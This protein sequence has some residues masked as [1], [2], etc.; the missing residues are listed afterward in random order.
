VSCVVLRPALGMCWVLPGRPDE[1]CW[2]SSS[3]LFNRQVA[4]GGVHGQA[5]QQPEAAVPKPVQ[6]S[7]PFLMLRQAML[8]LSAVLRAQAATTEEQLAGWLTP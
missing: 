6:T 7:A 3:S 5:A 1:G 4:G 8:L 2:L